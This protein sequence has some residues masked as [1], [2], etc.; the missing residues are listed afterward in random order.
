MVREL[1]DGHAHGFVHA[2]ISVVMENLVARECSCELPHQS[3]AVVAVP[4]SD[5]G[6]TP[7]GVVSEKR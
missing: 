3:L 5:G 2:N 1:S 4:S 6:R 7:V